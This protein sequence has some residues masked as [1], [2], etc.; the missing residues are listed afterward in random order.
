MTT[1]LDEI[2]SNLT[3]LQVNNKAA[4]R[5]AIKEGAEV[6]AAELVKNTPIGVYG[7]RNYSSKS[8]LAFGGGGGSDRMVDDVKIS[9]FRGGTIGT[10]EKDVGYG[11]STGYRVKYPNTGTVFQRPQNFKEHAINASRPKI[12]AVFAKHIKEGLKL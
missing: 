8:T 12:Q 10:I 9:G 1:G 3:K 2:L 6:F 4:A 5:R 7:P 11:K